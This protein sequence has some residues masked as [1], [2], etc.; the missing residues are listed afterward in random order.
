MSLNRRKYDRYF[1]NEIPIGNIGSIAEVSKK[2]LKIRKDPGFTLQSPKLN[3][4][5]GTSEIKT[6]V[7]WDDKTFIGV[8]F[9]G[10]FNDPKFIVSRL[11]RPK[12]T[13]VPPQMKV[14]DKAIQ[15][16]KKD[17][18]L[19]KMVNLLLEIESPEPNI[20]K[21]GTYI[22]EISRL[23]EAEKE[24]E[25]PPKEDKEAKDDGKTDKPVQETKQK[26]AVPTIKNELV[27]RAIVSCGEGQTQK[28]DIN[29][30][31]NR[32]GCDNVRVLIRSY[33]HK[34]IFKSENALPVFPNAE[35]YNILKSVVFRKL[36][37]LFGF[38]DIQP[39]GNALL[40]CE[41]VGV[42]ILIRESSG[43]LDNYYKS[44]YRVYSE[45]S[46]IYERSLF[47]VDPILI[48]KY[49]FEKSMGA[50]EELY[51]GYVLAHNILNTHY[52]PHDDIKLSLSKNSLAFSYIAYLTFLAVLFLMDRDAE[53]GFAFAKRL[54]GRGMN[55]Q[56]VI[57]FLDEAV[58]EAKALFQ[59]FGVKATISKPPL[60]S[61]SL[62]LESY[63][64][65]DA[66]FKYLLQSFGTFH[67]EKLKRM[68]IRYEDACYAH[69]VLGK[70]LNSTSFG[71]ASKTFVVVP[72]A[73]VAEDQWYVRDFEYF[74]LLIFKDIHKLPPFHMS[75]F[76][77]LWSSFEGQ[78]IITFSNTAFADFTQPQLY[79]VLNSYLVDFPSYF[80]NDAVYKKM[81]EHSVGFLK[82]F[83]GKEQVDTERYSNGV[84]TMTHIKRDTLLNKEIV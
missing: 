83:I 14:Q 1:I 13:D 46:R 49:Y 61:S 53:S 78:I 45:V 41:T 57:G 59:D 8:E 71:L 52:S 81:V 4:N 56:K 65:K 26:E 68:A 6:D 9:T 38:L 30:A 44:P 54:A 58:N 16:Y 20:R 40:S 48:N 39:E 12:E 11:K 17:E 27:E 2:G 74:D 33:A 69:F 51:N 82:P 62:N 10:V 47:G 34:R 77:K 31:I 76:L 50:F 80:L 22:D 43:I 19:Y 64:G 67:S 84:Y 3:F 5:I 35:P 55:D 29:F 15:Q 42:E 60:P 63:L 37:R 66:R 32:L 23:E 79:S 25:A 7:R 72:C 28:G 75:T 21:M 18:I 73:N 36:C 70:I 24:A